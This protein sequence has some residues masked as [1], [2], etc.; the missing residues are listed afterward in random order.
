MNSPRPNHTSEIERLTKVAVDAARS[1]QWDVVIQC[2]RDRG[3]LLETMQPALEQGEELLQ[4]DRQVC[5]HVQT[6]QAL[7]A[8][9]LGEAAA[10]KRRLQGLRQRLGVPAMA[11]EAMSMEA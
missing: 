6:T 8:S 10:T 1:G 9:L 7:L 3:N 2:Y 11:P 5:D 4:L